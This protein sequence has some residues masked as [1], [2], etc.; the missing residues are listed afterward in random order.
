MVLRAQSSPFQTKSPQAAILAGGMATRL[1]DVTQNRPKSMVQVGNKPFLQHQLELLKNS[2]VNRILL[3]LGYLGEQVEDYFKDGGWLGLEI[4]YSHENK[5]LG[6]AGAIKNAEKLLDDQFFTIYGDSYVF[7]DF[8]SVW[9]Y[10]QLKNKLALM[11]VYK[12]ED[13]YDTSNTIIQG[14]LVAYYS[15][16]QKTEDMR[17]ITQ[18]P[19][20]T[21]YGLED[22]FPQLIASRQLLAYEIN[23]RFYE[24]GSLNGLEEFKG[25]IGARK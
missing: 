12:N 18:I 17:H 1:G 10:F 25:Y 5:P 13:R 24:V 23:E 3:C 2:G 14:E 8:G 9:K 22:L 20:G 16:K 19:E 21:F 11:T 6:T 7:L 4:S 15:K